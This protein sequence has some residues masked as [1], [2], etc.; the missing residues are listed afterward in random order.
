MTF[1]GTFQCFNIAERGRYIQ[2]YASDGESREGGAREAET[3][4]KR[5]VSDGEWG[6]WLTVGLNRGLRLKKGHE[7]A[8]SEG[9]LRERLR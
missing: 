6:G 4:E 1:Y 8:M 7:R 3:R 9:D 2:I 5:E